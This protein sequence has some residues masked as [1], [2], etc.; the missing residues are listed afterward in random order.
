[1]EQVQA[2]LNTP[3]F[4]RLLRGSSKIN[5]YSWHHCARGPQVIQE[6]TFGTGNLLTPTSG[7]EHL[8]AGKSN[9]VSFPK[10]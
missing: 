1:M 3:C 8:A 6:V 4:S 9:G 2:A 5:I 7:N 10:N